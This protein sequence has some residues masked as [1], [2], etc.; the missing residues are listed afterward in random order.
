MIFLEFRSRFIKFWGNLWISSQSH[1]AFPTGFPLSSV[2]VC[3]YFLEQPNTKSEC[4]NKHAVDLLLLKILQKFTMSPFK[5]KKNQC[6][7]AVS[8]V[9]LPFWYHT[10][11]FITTFNNFNFHWFEQIFWSLECSNSRTL[12][13]HLNYAIVEHRI[14]LCPKWHS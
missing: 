13:A 14:R 6:Q 2:G 1:R 10:A 3:R 4:R 8:C 7:K 5:L 9:F 12:T 11:V